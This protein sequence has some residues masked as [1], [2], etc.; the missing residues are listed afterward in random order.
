MTTKV[1][2]TCEEQGVTIPTHIH[3]I[4][5]KLS[6]AVATDTT[7]EEEENGYSIITCDMDSCRYCNQKK[8]KQYIHK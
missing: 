6:F 3:N 8:E 4:A 7:E 5:K 1:S 2:T